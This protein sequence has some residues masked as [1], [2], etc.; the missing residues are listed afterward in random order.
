MFK[1]SVE[2]LCS[3]KARVVGKSWTL[4]DETGTCDAEDQFSE[5]LCT[6]SLEV[7][8]SPPFRACVGLCATAMSVKRIYAN[9]I[10]MRIFWV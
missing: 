4:R 3:T 9:V 1:G 6:E 10:Q 7:A 8:Y 2:S 5:L